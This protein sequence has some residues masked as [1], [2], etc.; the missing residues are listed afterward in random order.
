MAA[1]FVLYTTATRNGQG[2]PLCLSDPTATN[3]QTTIA[4]HQPGTTT[5]AIQDYKDRETKADL[6]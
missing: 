2:E 6:P 4:P 3:G 5:A 1:C